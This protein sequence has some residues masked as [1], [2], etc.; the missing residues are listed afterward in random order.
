M[1]N[2]KHVM[3]SM[4]AAFV[5]L[6]GAGHLNAQDRQDRGGRGNFDPEQMRA[7]MMERYRESFEV[8]DD[9]EWKLIEGRITKVMDARREMGGFGRG[10]GGS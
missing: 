9:A 2:S 10:F 1:R 5:L 4:A 3:M 7:R 6:L 8:K